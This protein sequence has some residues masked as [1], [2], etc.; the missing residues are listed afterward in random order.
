MSDS[1]LQIRR[2]E[3]IDGFVMPGFSGRFFMWPEEYWLLS[4]YVDLTQGDYL[5]IGSMCGIIAMSF[6][7]RFPLRQF[8]CVDKFAPGHA[9]IAGERETFQQNLRE[10]NLKN[11]TLYEGDSLEVVPTLTQSFDIIFVDANHAYDYVLGDAL[12]SWRLLLPGGFIAFHD[13]GYVE[14]TTRAVNEFLKRTGA[15]FLE[16]A[17]CLAVAQKPG[18]RENDRTFPLRTGLRDYMQERINDVNDDL[19][20]LNT[21]LRQR[22][23]ELKHL[24]GVEAVLRA[25]EESKSWRLLRALR[26]VRNFMLFRPREGLRMRAARLSQGVPDVRSTSGCAKTKR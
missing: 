17:S 24:R 9:T 12:N 8:V 26:N 19:D 10:H 3:I 21:E 6:A 22:E 1:E 7:E 2:V 13:Y 14:E 15:R 5:E 25:V 20:R 4:K 11:V 23:E 16:S 18:A